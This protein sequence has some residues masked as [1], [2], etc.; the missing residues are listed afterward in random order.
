MNQN[1]DN[2]PGRC[3]CEADP[4]GNAVIK[5]AG[6]IEMVGCTN[7]KGAAVAGA[8]CDPDG[9][10]KNFKSTDGIARFTACT[11]P[12][13]LQQHALTTPAPPLRRREQSAWISTSA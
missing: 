9:S 8:R 1:D 12:P 11:H 2:N 5:C 13:V 3:T 7:G 10:S 6:D 4:Q